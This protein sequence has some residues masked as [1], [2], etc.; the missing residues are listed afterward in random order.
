MAESL[1]TNW[2]VA[3][4]VLLV[5]IGAI[6]FEFNRRRWKRMVQTKLD[7]RPQLASDEFGETYFGE[8]ARRASIAKDLRE[9]LARHLPVSLDGLQPDDKFQETLKM[10]VFDSLSTVEVVMEIEQRFEIA[11]GNDEEV[12]PD[13]TFRQLVDFVEART[14][15]K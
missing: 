4:V 11:L 14:A 8:T 7:S 6:G 15:R 5:A 13:I 1:M 2:Q 12:K 10:D 9:I 3:V